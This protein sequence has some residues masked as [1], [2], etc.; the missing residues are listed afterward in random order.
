[1]KDKIRILTLNI[2]N[3]NMQDLLQE[4]QVI[5]DSKNKKKIIFTPNSEIAVL[6]FDDSDFSHM[7]NRADYLIP[8]GAGLLLAARI[9]N[10]NLKER[11]AGYD[12]MKNLLNIINGREGSIYFLGGRA[13]VIELAVK[14]I[15]REMEDINIAGYHHG[16]FDQNKKVKII[17]EINQKEP[18][19][20]LVG[21]GVPR[22]EEFLD[23]NID[24]LNIKIGLTVGGSFDVLAGKIKRAPLWMQK[25]YLEWFYRLLQEPKR[26]KRMF[27][28]PR[29]IFLNLKEKYNV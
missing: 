28:L 9:L 16:Y 27:R 3:I 25:I 22:Q 11:V 21:M 2:N 4:L 1:M 10:R 17:K 26:F 5:L 7:L 29:F 14:N 18:D 13:D 15:R 8:D 19:I 23:H 20:L 12:L 6:A 24:S